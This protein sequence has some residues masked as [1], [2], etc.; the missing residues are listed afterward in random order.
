MKDAV[1][2]E[3]DSN[4]SRAGKV[5]T[6]RQTPFLNPLPILCS[7]GNETFNIPESNIVKEEN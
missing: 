5:G 7:V 4:P 2:R 6:I 3:K 1:G